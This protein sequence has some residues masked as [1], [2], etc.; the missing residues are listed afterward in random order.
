MAT[1]IHHWDLGSTVT[2]W[3]KESRKYRCASSS[4]YV[5]MI[6][7]RKE[8]LHYKIQG[9]V[10]TVKRCWKSEVFSVR[11]LTWW[12]IM[13]KNWCHSGETEHLCLL[14]W[15]A[16]KIN[17]KTTFCIALPDLMVLGFWVIPSPLRAELARF[18]Q[19]TE[20]IRQQTQQWD[21]T[22]W[23]STFPLMGNNYTLS[24]FFTDFWWDSFTEEMAT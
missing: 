8:T 14:P 2:A 21:A 11:G 6:P 15:T 19:W 24:G 9:V 22:Q 10:Q 3:L 13:F 7:Y 12:I 20:S 5:D 4:S 1:V 16:V 18:T 17:W 23:Q